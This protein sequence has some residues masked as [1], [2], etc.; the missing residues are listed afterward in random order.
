MRFISYKTDAGTGV[1]VSTK[2][3]YRG[4]LVADLGFD[5]SGIIGQGPEATSHFGDILANA[6]VM[7]KDSYKLLPPIPKPDKIFCVGLNYRKHA[8]ESNTPI[9]T[10]PVI[11]SRYH[12]S[13]VGEGDP[14]IRPT[15]SDLLDYEVELAAIIG[16]P[17][18][19]IP[20][21]RALDH[22]AGYSVFNDASVRD[23]QV[24]TQQWF[25]GKNFDGTGAFGPELVTAD[26]LPPGGSG[27]RLEARVNGQ[28][29]QSDNT[30]DMIF[31]VATLVSILSEAMTL[32]AG[33]VIV[34]GTPS[35]VGARRNPP[36][37]LS[38][39]D[40]CEVEIEGIGVLSNPVE[41]ERL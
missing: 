40:R 8:E 10:Y 20:R 13:L 25:M 32:S 28:I 14:L 24:R 39:G 3:G 31:D 37:W 27:L 17:G 19:H 22:V 18:R 1:A 2:D 5:L 6:P 38:P 30:E 4:K 7:A 15:A 26:E 34:T 23:Y 29:L 36:I 41:Q 16:V 33:D 9:P 12:S 35:G 11:F 21:E